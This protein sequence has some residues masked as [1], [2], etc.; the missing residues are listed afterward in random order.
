MHYLGQLKPEL[1]SDL[2]SDIMEARYIAH[3]LSPSSLFVYCGSRPS[4]FYI[5]DLVST[6]SLF[7]VHDDDSST[8]TSEYSTKT[9]HSATS[10]IRHLP[11]TA[12]IMI[13]SCREIP[14]RMWSCVKHE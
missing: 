8:L 6:H 4:V 12:A 1:A 5:Y 10:S 14:Q 7:N 9:L 11:A 3:D 13:I 2:N